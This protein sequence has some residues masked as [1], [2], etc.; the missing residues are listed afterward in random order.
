MKYVILIVISMT[1]FTRCGQDPA[2][3]TAH[4][5]HHDH[6]MA[7]DEIHLTA[8]QVQLG[9]I[10]LDTVKARVLEEELLIPAL[11]SLD[12]QRITTVSARVMGRIEK[13]HYKNAGE[14]VKQGTVLF[15]IVSE[16]LLMAAKEFLLAR[17]T[18]ALA[19]EHKQLWLAAYNKLLL[20][21]LTAGQVEELAQSKSVPERFKILSPASGV[22]TNLGVREGEYVMKGSAVLQL[23][24]LASIWIEGQLYASAGTDISE[25]M[26]AQV[27]I[28]GS[29][30]SYT[31]K[32]SFIGP[33]LNRQSRIN[34]L[35]IVLSN[36]E[37]PVRP[38]TQAYIRLVTGAR[39]VLAIPTQAVIRE[40][41]GAVVW[42]QTG[43]NM[44]APRMVETGGESGELTE[45]KKGL[46][47][48][49]VYVRTGAYLVNSEFTFQKGMNPT[50]AHAT[51]GM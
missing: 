6:K 7:P 21:G 40:E 34:T 9:N 36:A 1:L 10:T 30:K 22:I 16:E 14:T 19:D 49:E 15:E 3:G 47:A 31:G 33:A 50:G 23:N 2:T 20:F 18:Q 51:H 25:G 28:A 26:Q 46:E 4:V 43:E 29:G 11:A 44:F 5:S 42:I 38:G 39:K 48:G 13:L 17:E 12:Q 32:I 37:A 24:D 35:R 27:E 8:Q 45:I 41:H